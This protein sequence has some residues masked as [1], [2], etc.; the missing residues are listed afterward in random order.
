MGR[1]PFYKWQKRFLGGGGSKLE[2]KENEAL[3]I[4]YLYPSCP[5]ISTSMIVVA[6]I[7]H[8]LATRNERTAGTTGINKEVFV[9]SLFSKDPLPPKNELVQLWYGFFR[10]AVGIL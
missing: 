7:S 8:Y 6:L 3:F 2:Q 4:L 1:D 5:F 10:T 9:L